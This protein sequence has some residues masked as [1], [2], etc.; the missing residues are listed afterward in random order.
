VPE[1]KGGLNAG[2]LIRNALKAAAGSAGSEFLKTD[3]GKEAVK[4]Q[5]QRE[6]LRLSRWLPW[7]IAGLAIGGLL[8]YA[9]RIRPR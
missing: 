4:E 2:L 9:A 1:V 3:V 7:L 8:L 5:V 6:A